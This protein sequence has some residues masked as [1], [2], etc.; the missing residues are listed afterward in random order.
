MSVRV[1]VYHNNNRHIFDTLMDRNRVNFKEGLPYL[2]GSFYV[3]LYH[4]HTH[5]LI[6]HT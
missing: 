2:Y 6:V 1:G 5:M 4:S 3:T